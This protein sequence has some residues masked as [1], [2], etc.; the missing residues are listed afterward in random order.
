VNHNAPSVLVYRLGSLGDTVVALPAFHAV[1]R[2]FR[3]SRITLLTNTPV[4]A[5]AAPAMQVLGPHYFVDETVDYPLHT[6]SPIVLCNLIR[7]IRA[8]RV[9][10]VVNLAAFRSLIRTKRDA[11]FFRAAGVRRLV[12]F[13]LGPK[14]TQGWRQPGSGETEWEALRIARRVSEIGHVD[15]EDNANW[16]LLL[17]KEEDA[18]ASVLLDGVP[19]TSKI[20]AISLG[21]KVPAKDWGGQNWRN[22]VARLSSRMQGWTAVFSGSSDESSISAKCAQEW[23]GKSINICGKATPRES[24][25]I[26]KRSRLFI[27]HDSGPMHMAACV[28][29]PCVAIFSARHFPRQW[30]PRGR[31]NRIIYRR[32]NCAGCA[33]NDCIVEQKK[34]ILSIT[35]D[36]VE[37]AVSQTLTTA[38][39]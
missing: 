32:V 20:L 23:Q 33:L 29:T 17:T 38:N 11:L 18:A 22:L 30:F 39:P 2:A 6:R 28:G 4:N 1:R 24:A 7:E 15:L 9:D 27:G 37:E 35:V 12:G 34:C 8:R 31:H 36:E 25:A 3:D 10:T 19:D 16:D 14:D 5:K 26:Y 13:R 21:T